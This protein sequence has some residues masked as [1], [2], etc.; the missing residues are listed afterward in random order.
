[1]SPRS[2]RAIVEQYLHWRVVENSGSLL[3]AAI[4]LSASHRLSFWDA[5]VVQAAV[6]AGCEHLY[7]EDLQHGRKFGKLEIINP[8]L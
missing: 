8:F 4:E 5:L 2:A 1:M 7:S 3:L 6:A